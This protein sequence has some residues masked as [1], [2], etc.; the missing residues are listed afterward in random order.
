[1][2][3]FRLIK[4]EEVFCTRDYK[5]NGRVIKIAKLSGFEDNLI[6]DV[7]SIGLQRFSG[8]V[9]KNINEPEEVGKFKKGYFIKYFVFYNPIVNQ[10]K[11]NL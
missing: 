1:M 8:Y 11:L 4:V 3:K 7:T 10:L 5:N 6:I 9:K 2:S